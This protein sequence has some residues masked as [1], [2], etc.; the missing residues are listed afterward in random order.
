MRH[1]G[2]DRYVPNARAVLCSERLRKLAVALCR[3]L[4]DVGES[5]SL[6]KCNEWAMGLCIA[7]GGEAVA[8]LRTWMR[9]PARQG[10][11]PSYIFA[12]NQTNP[13]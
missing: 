5:H 11:T 4:H 6:S 13:A 2:H 3:W 9:A 8:F 1:P 7:R 12:A 10:W